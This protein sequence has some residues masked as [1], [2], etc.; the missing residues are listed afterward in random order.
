MKPLY[1]L[2]ASTLLSST[3]SL[4]VMAQDKPAADG[5]VIAQ[6]APGKATIAEE[7]RVTATVQAVDVQQRVVTL[8]DP[9]GNVFKTAVGPEV[10]NLAQVKAGDRVVVRYLQALSLELKKN[11]KEMRSR[12]D[13]T[14]GARAEAG[15]RPGGIAAQQVE[16]TADVIAVNTKTRMVKL[17]GPEHVVDLKVRDPEQLKLIKVGDQIHAVYAQALALSVE[18]APKR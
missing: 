13:T 4:A 14:D 18:P 5:A 2:A 15:T 1:L 10:R 6:S 9:K 12:I 16:V 3:L 17:R 8:K 11:G 7:V